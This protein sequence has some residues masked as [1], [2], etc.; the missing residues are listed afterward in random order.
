[1]RLL[2][3][4]RVWLWMVSAAD[5]LSAEIKSLFADEATDLY[6]STAS[7][8]EIGIKHA[9]GKLRL[10]GQPAVQVPLYITRS[11]AQ[12]L[13]VTVEHALEPRGFPPITAIRST[14]C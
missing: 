2:L 7:V 10:T 12:P 8:W 4:T 6:L 9:A 3:D 11:G 5:R 14:A 1:M 13:V